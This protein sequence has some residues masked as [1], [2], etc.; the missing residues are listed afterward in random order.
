MNHVC[1]ISIGSN[2]GNRILNIKNSILELS[3]FSL[4][5]KISSY[6]ETSPWGYED[7]H[8]YINVVVKIKTNFSPH[9][10]LKKLKTIENKMG[11][12]LLDDGI[13]RS[14]IIDLDI[15]FFDDLILNEL[16]LIIQHPKLYNRK[17]VLI[18]LFEIVTNFIC[19]FTKKKIK[20]I[21]K[22][23]K[24]NTIISRYDLK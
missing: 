20:V 5:S 18:P 4:I 24:D 17:F 10:L 13:Y 22:E 7:I 8:Q 21:L 15:L 11:R 23:L 14:R 16:D 12:L 2:L 6:Y 1:Y 9:D 19:P 3:S